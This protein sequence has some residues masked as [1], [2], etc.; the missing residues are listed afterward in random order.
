[1]VTLEYRHKDSQKTL[2]FTEK[3]EEKLKQNDTQNMYQILR[4]GS[5]FRKNNSH[6]ATL[7]VK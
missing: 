3:L 5:T 2:K 6:H 7:I 4:G 1:M